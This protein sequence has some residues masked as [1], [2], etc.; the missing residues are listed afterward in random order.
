MLSTQQLQELMTDTVRKA[1]AEFAR[2]SRPPVSETNAAEGSG[3]LNASS[4]G[5]SLLFIQP[6][7]QRSQILHVRR[8]QFNCYSYV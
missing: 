3:L 8:E 7:A 1:I 2:N 6:S 5:E 4:L